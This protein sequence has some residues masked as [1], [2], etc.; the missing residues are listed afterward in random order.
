[1][2][3]F[4]L[5][6]HFPERR[7]K[8]NTHS[9]ISVSDRPLESWKLLLRGSSLPLRWMGTAL[10]HLEQGASVRE[11][12]GFWVASRT[13]TKMKQKRKQFQQDFFPLEVHGFVTRIRILPFISRMAQDSWPQVKNLLLHTLSYPVRQ[14]AQW[15]LE[16]AAWLGVSHNVMRLTSLSSSGTF[17]WGFKYRRKFGY[18]LNSLQIIGGDE[19]I[20]LNMLKYINQS[21]IRFPKGK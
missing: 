17:H 4:L 18:S 15:V 20:W 19:N 5:P 16:R 12:A 8:A 7:Q 2:L 11:L 13:N 1:M 10:Y 9:H 3:P 21:K 14:T 6:S